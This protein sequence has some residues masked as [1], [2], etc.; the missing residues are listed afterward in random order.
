M[1]KRQNEKDI[2]RRQGM[3]KRAG[4]KHI[5]DNVMAL[6]CDVDSDIDAQTVVRDGTGRKRGYEVNYFENMYH[7]L[8][9][10]WSWL[11]V[12]CPML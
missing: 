5:K 8:P 10:Q 9:E 4:G 2:H 1:I 7:R 11:S 6:L 3:K 12:G